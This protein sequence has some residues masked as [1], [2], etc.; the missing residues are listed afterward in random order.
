MQILIVTG[1]W[2]FDMY[3]DTTEILELDSNNNEIISPPSAWK[4]A[5]NLP[6]AR[7]SFKLGSINNVVYLF[8][9][10]SMKYL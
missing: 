1:G 10:N 9:K 6:N 2:I 8:G 3:I 7:A 4:L 5:G